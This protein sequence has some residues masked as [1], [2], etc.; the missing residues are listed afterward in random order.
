MLLAGCGGKRVPPQIAEEAGPVIKRATQLLEE[1]GV[2]APREA[3]AVETQLTKQIK[4]WDKIRLTD[5]LMPL[6]PSEIAIAK[7]Q[8]KLLR[9]RY[10]PQ[11]Y[12]AAKHILDE[13]DLTSVIFNVHCEGL[14]KELEGQP[15]TEYDYALLVAK[16]AA[17]EIVD[18]R[19]PKPPPQKRFT[20][21]VKALSK[22]AEDLRADP[23]TNESA[24]R[25]YVDSICAMPKFLFLL[26]EDA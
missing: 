13:V 8:G 6:S 20:E 24:R 26:K 11:L 25:A 21:I 7:L 3:P 4:W 5:P 1:S 9:Q 17:T 14:R 10:E 12:K 2:I 23:L 16:E 18:G 19:L 22:V 15:L